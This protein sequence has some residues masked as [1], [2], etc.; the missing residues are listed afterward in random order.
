METTDSAVMVADTEEMVISVVRIERQGEARVA[1]EVRDTL[2][3]NSL[4]TVT[5]THDL[6]YVNGVARGM[7]LDEVGAADLM[8]IFVPMI[9]GE[10]TQGSLRPEDEQE[11]KEDHHA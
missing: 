5:L 6:I 2:S 7:H 1:I 4:L 11:G 8:Q 10:W 3:D 9:R